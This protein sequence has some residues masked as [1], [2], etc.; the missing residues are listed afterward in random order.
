MG[1]EWTRRAL[2][3]GNTYANNGFNWWSN[4]GAEYK[5][6]GLLVRWAFLPLDVHV[7]PSPASHSPLFLSLAPIVFPSASLHSHTLTNKHTY[8]QGVFLSGD[9]YRTLTDACPETEDGV[10][11]RVL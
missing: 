3:M 7:N 11:V 2:A 8:T 1:G 5:G 10:L 4:A 6:S 9:L